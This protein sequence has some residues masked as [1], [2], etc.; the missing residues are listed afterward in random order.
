MM[1]DTISKERRSL[2]MSKIKSKNTGPEIIVRSVLHQMGYRF[3]LHKINLPGSPDIVLPKY[4]TVFFVHGCFW[5][6]HQDCR[7]AYEPKSRTEFW[8]EKFYENILRDLRNR[9]NIEKMGWKIFVIWECETK[10]LSALTKTISDI[11]KS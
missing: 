3:R 9:E 6:R 4:K 11:L 5:H 2:N 10:D 7:Y 1:A 8:Q